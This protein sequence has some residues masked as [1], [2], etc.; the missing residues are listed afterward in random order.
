MKRIFLTGILCLMVKITF[1]Q[2]QD[3]IKQYE[4]DEVVV[5]ATRSERRIDNIPQK[6][7]VVSLKEIEQTVSNNVTDILKKTSGVD[8]VQYPGLLSG[9][10]IRGFRPQFSGVNQ[11]TLILI[12]GRPAGATNLATIDM[13]N[14]KRVEV[15]KGPASSLYGAQAMG[16]VVNI[17]TKKTKGDIGGKVFFGIGNFGRIDNGFALGGNIINKLD[18]DLNLKNYIQRNDFKIGKANVFRDI[19]SGDKAT[20]IIWTKGGKKEVEIDDTRG[21]GETRE[22][23]SYSSYSV[24]GRL[25]YSINNYWRIDI[26]TDVFFAD[27]VNTPGDIASGNK[28]PGLKDVDRMGSD[29]ILKGKIGEKNELTAK[30][31]ISSENSTYYHLS[32]VNPTTRRNSGVSRD[33]KLNWIGGQIMDRHRFG[34]HYVTAGIDLNHVKQD[35]I[36]F[37]K[38]GKPYPISAQYPNFTQT[39]LGMYLQG[40][41]NLFDNKLNATIG[42]RNEIINHDIIGTDLFKGRSEQNNI[43]NPSFGVKYQFLPNLYAHATYGTAFTPVSAFQIAGYDERKI[44]GTTNTV[45]VWIGNPDLKNLTSQTFDIGIQYVNPKNGLSFDFTYFH[46]NFDNNV[47]NKVEKYPGILA[48]SGAVIRNKNTYTNAKG[49]TLEGV[50]FD[51]KYP[52]AKTGI[53]LFAGVVCILNA[54]EIRDVYLQ[55][56]PLTLEMHN[57]ADLTLNYGISYDKLSWLSTKLSGRYVGRRYDTDWAYYGST[58][59]GNYADIKYPSFMVLD[60]TATASYNK[61][62]LTLQIGNISDE[63]YYEK[64]GFNLMGRNYMLKYTLNF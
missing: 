2:K 56:E 43:V 14:V 4:L 42:V 19:L 30:A 32:L 20:R 58:S 11:K 62:S 38:D 25:G 51:I 48:E 46:T 45:D 49:T 10:G 23:T 13:N 21:D 27:G 55:P 1:S 26:K 36:S 44:T 35:N 57:V 40:E 37:G 15:L 41:I 54:K 29:L 34:N 6:M 61:S 22:N 50:E 64:R 12:D 59:Y 47:I 7:S 31:F 52:L 39:N 8:V 60:F 5:T 18:F 28:F 63:N 33:N 24:A 17:I 3:S 16:G 53:N 9:I